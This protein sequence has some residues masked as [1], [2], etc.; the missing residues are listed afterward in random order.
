MRVMRVIAGNVPLV[1]VKVSKT[2]NIYRLKDTPQSPASPANILIATGPSTTLALTGNA[3]PGL[4]Q[5]HGF[6]TY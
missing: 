3:K 2:N 4:S 1:R 5:V 6:K